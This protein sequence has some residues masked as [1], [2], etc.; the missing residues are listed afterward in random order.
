MMHECA[1][2]V[3]HTQYYRQEPEPS[4]WLS[5]ASR[6]IPATA[7]RQRDVAGSF[8]DGRRKLMSDHD[9]LEHQA[10][11]F[12]AAILMPASMVRRVFDELEIGKNMRV[13]NSKAS[14]YDF[15]FWLT[16]AFRVSAC[17]A[18]IRIRQLSLDFESQKAMNPSMYRFA[19]HSFLL[20]LNQ[21]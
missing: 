13:S 18:R 14:E 1:H 10:K 21:S 2:K 15:I 4:I 20:P 16:M 9:W 19:S 5:A 6:R 12:S 8:I 7:C 11:Y 3:Y 17:S